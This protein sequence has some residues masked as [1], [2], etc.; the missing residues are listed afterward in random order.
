M[1]F[2]SPTATIIFLIFIASSCI[3]G[4]FF[5]TFRY[6]GAAAFIREVQG[7]P[8][9]WKE[10]KVRLYW[11]SQIYQNIKNDSKMPNSP[12]NGKKNSGK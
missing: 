10:S 8:F 7:Y 3:C 1:I 4:R 2:I 6:V 12:R 9:L 11:R 5:G